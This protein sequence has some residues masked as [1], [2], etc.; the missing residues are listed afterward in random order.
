MCIVQQQGEN[1]DDGGQV[2]EQPHRDQQQQ[3]EEACREVQGGFVTKPLSACPTQGTV[4]DLLEWAVPAAVDLQGHG[5][6]RLAG[7]AD[8]GDADAEHVQH[9]PEPRRS[10][11]DTVR[12]QHSPEPRRSSRPGRW[13][14]SKFK[15]F[16]R[17]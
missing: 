14:T 3:H 11:A 8:R 4:E 5:Q 2:L 10:Y 1:G 7:D 17:Y 13:E 15:D 9:N 6:G 12:V 16:V